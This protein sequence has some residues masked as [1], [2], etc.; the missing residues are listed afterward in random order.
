LAGFSLTI[1]NI[2]ENSLQVQVRKVGTECVILAGSA[3]FALEAIFADFPLVKM[4]SG[5]R[6]ARFLKD[7]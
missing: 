2:L 5:A 3:F 4:F 6:S 1:G 7:F